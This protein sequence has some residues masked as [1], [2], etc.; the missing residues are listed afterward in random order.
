M[1]KD[2]ARADLVGQLHQHQQAADV[3]QQPGGEQAFAV[4]HV[5]ALRKVAGDQAAVHAVLP[6]SRHV[7][8]VSRNAGKH[9]SG[10]RRHGQVAQFT[11]A[12]QVHCTA[13][14]VDL[15][16]QTEVGAV[17][18]LQQAGGERGVFTDDVTDIG[19][20]GVR[21]VGQRLHLDTD[22]RQRNQSYVA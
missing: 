17:D 22:L 7:D 18:Q 10:G 2:S 14:G 11:H 21:R 8:Q 13:Y 15:A 19:G 16:R 9:F 3:V 4:Q 1:R 5:T 6:E 20:R 12:D